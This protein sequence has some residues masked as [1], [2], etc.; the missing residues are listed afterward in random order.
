[1]K[2]PL[3]GRFSL[4]ARA[5]GCTAAC[6]TAMAPGLGC[7][8]GWTLEGGGKLP[9]TRELGRGEGV[10]LGQL[11]SL[12]FKLPCP[13]F[14]SCG[15]DTLT[16][17]YCS[18]HI[19]KYLTDLRDQDK[20]TISVIIPEPLGK[21]T[22]DQLAL[23]YSILGTIVPMRYFHNSKYSFRTYHSHCAPSCKVF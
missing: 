23:A 2:Q 6:L 10:C 15:F 5:S 22:G 19:E 20:S 1:M 7:F 8:K 14:S 17:W 18:F 4:R 21:A 16:S 9:G 12:C 3:G 13:T 11:F